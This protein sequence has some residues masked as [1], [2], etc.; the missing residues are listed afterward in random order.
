MSVEVCKAWELSQDI[1]VDDIRGVAVAKVIVCEL[2]VVL[3][4]IKHKEVDP[5]QA[6]AVEKCLLLQEK[7]K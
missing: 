4:Q 2:D 6:T 7:Y 5:S 3:K 1:Y